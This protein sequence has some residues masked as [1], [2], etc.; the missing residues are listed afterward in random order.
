MAKPFFEVLRS[1]LV[2]GRAS[3]MRGKVSIWR[4]SALCATTVGSECVYRKTSNI[5][6][7]FLP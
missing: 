4:Q 6:R 1:L 5:I 2:F 3:R 7:T